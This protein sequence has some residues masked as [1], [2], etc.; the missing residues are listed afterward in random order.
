MQIL[1]N[2][3]NNITGTDAVVAEVES[4]VE[5]VLAR[6][7]SRLTRVEVHLSDES[8]GRATTDDI[9]CL[10]EVRPAG[11][12]PLAA[13][14]NAGTVNGAVSGALRK[15]ASVLD[16]TFGRLDEHK[17]ASAMGDDPTP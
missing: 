4:S 3:D 13:T 1:V 7:S 10:L 16:T 6:F 5:S 12:N 9:R 2:T 8:A 14:D 17:G 11:G 15:L